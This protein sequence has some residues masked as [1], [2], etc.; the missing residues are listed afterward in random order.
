MAHHAYVLYGPTLRSRALA[1][2]WANAGHATSDREIVELSY[3]HFS[4]EDARALSDVAYSAPATGTEKVVMVSAGRLFHAAQNALLKI[5]EEPPAHTT[6]ILMVP[7]PGQLLPTLRSRLIA[8]PGGVDGHAGE[9]GSRERLAREFLEADVK[10]R[11]KMVSKIADAAKSEK[12]EVKQAARLEALSLA[13]GL[14]IATRAS[15]QKKPASDTLALM[16]DLEKLIPIL[17]EASAPLKQVLEH[18]V[19][20][21]PPSLT[22][23]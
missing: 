23:K 10:G 11:E 21:T 15:S 6:L 8:L 22:Q 9:E 4:V 5:F 17:H 20:V 14:L 2:A 19:I 7:S 18:V 16:A 12:E 1:H 3:A 13:E